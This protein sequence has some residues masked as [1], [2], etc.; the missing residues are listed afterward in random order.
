M[1]RQTYKHI[2]SE[3]NEHPD[4]EPLI[5]DQTNNCTVWETNLQHAAQ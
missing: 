1:S 3:H 4:L 5:E 2:T